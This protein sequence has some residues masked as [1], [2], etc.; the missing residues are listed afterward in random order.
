MKKIETEEPELISIQE[1]YEYKSILTRMSKH[2]RIYTAGTGK[3]R[4]AIIITNSNID[5]ILI[6]KLS[7]EDTVAL[8]TIYEGMSFLAASMY[9]DIDDQI[10]NNLNEMFKLVRFAKE[11]RIVIAVDNNARS[12]TWHD[13]KTNARGRKLEEYLVSR[14][15]HIV[16]EECYRPTFFNSI[17]TSNIDLTIT[18]NNL[19]GKVSEWDIS[20]EDSL[21]DHNYIQYTI[22]EGGAEKQNINYR[23]QGTKL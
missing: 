23:K 18:N 7:D 6:S 14:H 17:G 21:S 19:L 1:P 9:F 20:N 16:N 11:G 22:R 3:Y 15:L 13:A 5:A 12:K 4:A 2:Y 10:Q 8:E